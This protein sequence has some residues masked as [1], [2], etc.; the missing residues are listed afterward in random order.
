MENNKK[1][2]EKEN[3]LDRNLAAQTR[4]VMG[5]HR[6]VSDEE[7]HQESRVIRLAVFLEKLGKAKIR[8]KSHTYL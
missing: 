1:N 8:F 3:D 6:V 4:V 5:H 2:Q 7:S